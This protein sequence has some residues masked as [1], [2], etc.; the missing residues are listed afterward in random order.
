MRK[1]L[2]KKID[3]RLSIEATVRLED[4]CK[5]GHQDFAVT[6]TIYRTTAGPNRGFESGGC[7]H[8]EI[9]QHFPKL[10]PFIRLHLC[11]FAGVPMHGVSDM[12][13]HLK[14][15]PMAELEFCQNYRCSIE[16]YA[17]FAAAENEVHFASLLVES[18]LLQ[19]WQQQAT[20]AIAI[21]EGMTGQMFVNTSTRSNLRLPTPEQLAEVRKQVSEGYFAPEKIEER[22]QAAAQAAIAAADTKIRKEH[23]EH[24][25]K[26]EL[27]MSVK[28]AILHGAGIVALKNSI[29]YNHT[30]T[31]KFNWM[32]CGKL[33]QTTVDG[34]KSAIT[35]PDGVSFEA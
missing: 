21:L 15:E 31:V 13:F 28:L 26:S 22:K 3:S 34:F 11:D 35:L 33:P 19:T 16:Q 24:V 14:T 25:R 32:S 17:T 2:V 12:F 23:D 10:E 7:I 9:L 8:E 6:G 4:D 5:N 18:G 20:D 29:F 30:K 27:E 1:Q